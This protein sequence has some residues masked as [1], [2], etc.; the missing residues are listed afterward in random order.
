[1]PKAKS[2]KGLLKRIRVT[3]RGK[4]KHKRSGGTHLMSGFSGDQKRKLR[5]AKIV[6]KP[7]AKKLEGALHR[8]LKGPNE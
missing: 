1:M 3:A 5:S 7:V 8:H 6:P 2:H 4:V